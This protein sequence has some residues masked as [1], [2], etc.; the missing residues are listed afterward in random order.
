LSLSCDGGWPNS[1]QIINPIIHQSINPHGYCTSRKNCC[2]PEMGLVTVFCPLTLTGAGEL[3]V[4]TADGPRFAVDCKM[5]PEALVG[6]F[7]M[8]FPPEAAI[9]SWGGLTG[10]EMLNMVP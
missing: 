7:R 9:V 4:Q 2:V 10:N 6:Q 8:T 3:V 5:N 1:R